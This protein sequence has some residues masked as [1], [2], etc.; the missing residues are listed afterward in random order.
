MI[1]DL[2]KRQENKP[3]L[4]Y[5]LYIICYRTHLSKQQYDQDGCLSIFIG[6]NVPNFNVVID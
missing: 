3:A 6:E 5:L 1:Y 2:K 4:Q